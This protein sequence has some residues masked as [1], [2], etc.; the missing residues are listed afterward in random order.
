MYA[1]SLLRK[2]N[3]KALTTTTDTMERYLHTAA[4]QIR[5]ATIPLNKEYFDPRY[6][7]YN[8]PTAAI[9]KVRQHIKGG[10][11]CLADVNRSRP[12]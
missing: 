8:R 9:A 2:D 7:R 4:A 11:L 10:R 5:D 3:I 1:L 12:L 6:D